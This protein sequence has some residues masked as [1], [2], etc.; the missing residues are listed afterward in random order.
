MRIRYLAAAVVTA[1]ALMATLTGAAN[2]S[3]AP[4]P[5]AP[6]ET[7]AVTCEGAEGHAVLARKLTEAE[8]KELQAKG[9]TPAKAT[10]PATGM[11]IDKLPEGA[12]IPEFPEGVTVTKLPDGTEIAKLPEGAEAP[13][14][15]DV[16][17]AVPALPATPL[18]SSERAG[19]EKGGI[20][21]PKDDETVAARV[22][23][24][25]EVEVGK[26]VPP[27]EGVIV[28]C[29]KAERAEDFKAEPAEEAGGR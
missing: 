4:A 24:A 15:P 21:S 12:E 7:V 13:G 3:D 17:K 9:G 29:S 10:M 23:P 1:G 18:D 5:T 22:L 16:V 11:K 19:T 8:V 25:E 6:A 27:A 14:L 28:T 20:L 26:A 2:A